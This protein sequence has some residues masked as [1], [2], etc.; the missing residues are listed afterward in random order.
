MSAVVAAAVKVGP[1]R[2][3]LRELPWPSVAADAGLLRIEAAGICGSDVRSYQRPARHG[4]AHVMGH[5]NVGTVVAIG[6]EAARRWNVREGDRVV[7]EEYLP[8]GQCDMCRAGEHRFC[9]QTNIHSGRLAIRYGSTP[10]SVAPG[11]WGGFSEVLYMHPAS[12]VHPLDA[13]TPAH[14]AALALP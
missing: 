9:E 5:E 10:L 14:L 6:S 1:G 7:L 3:E 13:R 11:L 2:T 8:C 4:E 12:V